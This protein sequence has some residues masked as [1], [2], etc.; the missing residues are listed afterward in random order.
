MSGGVISG[1]LTLTHPVRAGLDHGLSYTVETTDDLKFGTWTSTESV[2]D[3][4]TSRCFRSN[5]A[6][7]FFNK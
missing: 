7:S 1:N 4:N 2:S 3:I 5:Y 6:F